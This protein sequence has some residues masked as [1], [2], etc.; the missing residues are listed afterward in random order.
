MK[1]AISIIGCFIICANVIIAQETNGTIEKKIQQ[2]T[3]LSF[4]FATNISMQ[5][6]AEHRIVFPFLQGTN[7][8]TESS[9]I[10]LKLGTEITPMTVNFYTDA[11]WAPLP[12]LDV[13]LG[14]EAGTGWNFD[15]Y[16]FKMKGMGLYKR[17]NNLTPSEFVEGTG[18]DGVLL[19]FHGG[20]TLKFDLAAFLPGK[21][22]HAV[23]KFD[24]QLHYQ[25]Y[26]GANGSEPWYF[27][28]GDGINQNWFSY[29]FAGFAGYQMPIFL[30]LA[31]F[32]FELTQPLY[33]PQSGKPLGNMEPEMICSILLE[34]EIGNRFTFLTLTE[35]SNLLTHPLTSDYERIWQFSCVRILSTWHIGK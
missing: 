34:F 3:D 10:T 29:Y 25:N 23:I 5:L 21:W 14:A 7:P 16:G 17:D 22:N 12:F 18:L 20:A 13:L 30:D 9:N 33:N 24:N 32:M 2:E 11:I 4:M 35:F 31:G 15:L 26:T 19:N 8:L 6:A 27:K 1:K 28:G